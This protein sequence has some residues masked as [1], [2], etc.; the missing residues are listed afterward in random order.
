MSF[1]QK[2]FPSDRIN[3]FSDAIFAIGITLLVLEIKVPTSTEITELGVSGL[4]YKRL[5]YF[6]GYF[7][8]F[9]VTALYWKSHLQLFQWVK[10]V[11]NKLL[12]LNLWLLFFVVL[13][14][15]STAL[16]SY[17]FDSDSAFSFYS[18]NLSAM[19]MMTYWMTA[20]VAKK[21][22]LQEEMSVQRVKWM[23][24]RA[25]VS[26]LVFLLAI[27]LLWLS[28]WISRLSFFLIFIFQSIGDR[29]LKKKE[30]AAME[31]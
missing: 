30:D 27:P 19:G 9:M 15:F 17:F 16:Y 11:D 3:N 21:E 7:V 22:K 20:Y 23:K 4:L 28:P 2:P 8:S 13:L 25:L 5:P 31:V 26:P 1:L 6:I 12:W 29:R 18:L 10:S 14:P 24:N